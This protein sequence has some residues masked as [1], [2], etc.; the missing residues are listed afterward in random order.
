MKSS[1]CFICVNLA[2][3]DAASVSAILDPTYGVLQHVRRA[4]EADDTDAEHL[5]N[6]LWFIANMVAENANICK[7]VIKETHI[8]DRLTELT[9]HKMKQCL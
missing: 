9:G 3:G 8:L 4:L 7:I 6:L 5:H 2:M 1:A